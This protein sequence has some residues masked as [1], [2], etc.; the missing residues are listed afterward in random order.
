MRLVKQDGGDLLCTLSPSIK[1]IEL[2]SGSLMY[3]GEDI[4]LHEWQP[5]GEASGHL[6]PSWN[7][8]HFVFA[9]KGLCALQARMRDQT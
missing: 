5:L 2:T 8:D 7:L 6:H 4:F 1:T 9:Y 3:S